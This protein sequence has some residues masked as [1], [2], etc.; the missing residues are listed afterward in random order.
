MEF[1]KQNCESSLSLEL[2]RKYMRFLELKKHVMFMHIFR[3]SNLDKR[4][5]FR[6]AVKLLSDTEIT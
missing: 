1:A 5:S 3:P 4:F 2:E 6:E